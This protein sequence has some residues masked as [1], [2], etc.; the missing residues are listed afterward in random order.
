[1]NVKDSYKDWLVEDIRLDVQRRTFPYSVCMENWEND[2]NLGQLIR[3]AN[4]FGAREVYYLQDKR[5]FDRRSTVGCH[6]YTNLIHLSSVEELRQLK[7]DG[8]I[9]GIV[10]VEN[11]VEFPGKILNL[12]DYQKIQEKSMLLFGSERLGLSSE[13][14]KICDQM[15]TIP[16]FGSVRSLNCATCA[17]IVL[18]HVS[19]LFANSS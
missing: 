17:G 12:S 6:N 2:F 18:N 8:V 10:A 3:N 5:K 9:S 11:N 7:E 16:L 4:A 14:L 1:M 19:Q 15:I 13:I